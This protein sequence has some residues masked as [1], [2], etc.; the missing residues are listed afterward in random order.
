[1]L[2]LQ[3]EIPLAV[4]EYAAEKAGRHALT[5]IRNPAPADWQ[6]RALA[7]RRLCQSAMKWTPHSTGHS[8]ETHTSQLKKHSLL[9]RVTC[10]FANCARSWYS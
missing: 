3:F 5:T 9:S 1:M 8:D 6:Q 4:V 7:R 10:Q 2:L